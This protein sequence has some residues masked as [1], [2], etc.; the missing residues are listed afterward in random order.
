MGLST[1][2][3]GWTTWTTS[4]EACSQSCGGGT[5]ERSRTCTN[6]VPQFDGDDCAG[7][8]TKIESCNTQA[9]PPGKKTG[10]LPPMHPT[11]SYFLRCLEST[12]FELRDSSVADLDTQNFIHAFFFFRRMR[13]LYQL[14]P[15]SLRP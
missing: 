4:D 5:V 14:D 1:V 7:N 9:C 11:L 6:P 2:N 8:A 12:K 10:F 3:G 15:L 13:K